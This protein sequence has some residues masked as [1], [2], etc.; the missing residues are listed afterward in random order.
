VEIAAAIKDFLAANGIRRP[1]LRKR[2]F[3]MKAFTSSPIRADTIP[4]R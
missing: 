1:S 2:G 4:E 3:K